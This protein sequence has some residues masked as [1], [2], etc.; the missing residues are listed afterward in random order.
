METWQ[1]QES[2]PCQHSPTLRRLENVLLILES[3]DETPDQGAEPAA[4]QHLGNWS[5]DPAVP[6]L[7]TLIS[8]E[9][10]LPIV[11]GKSHKKMV[12]N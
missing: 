8:P 2:L 3:K 1:K 11:K 7:A 10:C 4:C 9:H 6:L 12:F 5:L